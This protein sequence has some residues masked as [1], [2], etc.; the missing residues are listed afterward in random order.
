MFISW[1]ISSGAKHRPT[2][3]CPGVIILSW[4]LPGWAVFK[5][6]DPT[7]YTWHTIPTNHV[8]NYLS[9]QLPL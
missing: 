3:S 4:M 9:K 1:V 5:V 2:Y 6:F 8:K 7:L